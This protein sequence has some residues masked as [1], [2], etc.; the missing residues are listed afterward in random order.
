MRLTRSI[1]ILAFL[2]LV[3]AAAAHAQMEGLRA[4]QRVVVS[5]D[6]VEVQAG[7]RVVA[8]EIQYRP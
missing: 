1:A 3:G 4:D 8:E 2:L 5:L 7:A 6:R